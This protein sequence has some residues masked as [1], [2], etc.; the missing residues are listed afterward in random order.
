KD[1][2]GMIG[3]NVGLRKDRPRMG[4][5]NFTEKVEYWAMMWG[6]VLMGLTGFML[7]NPIATTNILPGQFIPAAKVAHGMEAVL[8]V[9]AI[10]IWHFYNVHIKK[11]NWSMIKGKLSHEEM[12][13]EHAG[14][15]DE[16]ER[17]EAGRIAPLADIRKRRNIF[18]PLAVVFALVC[19]FAIYQFVTYEETALTT[20][21][22]AA[23]EDAPVFSVPTTVPEALPSS[24]SNGN[25]QPGFHDGDIGKVN[26]G[27]FRDDLSLQIIVP[28]GEL[29]TR[30]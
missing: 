19:L 3:Y 6:L 8:A 28:L 22:P 5:Y 14:E 12:E 18:I 4:R 27:N 26:P 23:S 10:L 7:W 9:L 16:I 11:W 2:I 13:E 29:M 1:G 20:I 24:E 17:G 21:A 30:V 25:V 15:L